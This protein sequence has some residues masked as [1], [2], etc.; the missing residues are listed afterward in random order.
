MASQQL[1]QPYYVKYHD[2]AGK[3]FAFLVTK[4]DASEDGTLSQLSGAVWCDDLDNEAGLSEGWNA[5]VQ[6]GRAD[7]SDSVPGG[8]S[9]SPFTETD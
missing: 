5:R 8:A 2:G 1:I 7:D 6:I 3:A 9:W 4:A